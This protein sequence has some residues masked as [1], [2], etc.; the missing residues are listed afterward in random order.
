MLK[1]KDQKWVYA[2]SK[3]VAISLLLLIVGL[4]IVLLDLASE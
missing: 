2:E 1:K 4:K 3:F